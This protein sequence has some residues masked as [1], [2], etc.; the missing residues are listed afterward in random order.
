MIGAADE[1]KG[2]LPVGLLA[3]KAGV[4]RPNGDIAG[5][6]VKMVR[7]QIGAVASFKTATVVGR[8]PK[9][10]SGKIL[11][12][13]MREIADSEHYKTPATITLSWQRRI[14]SALAPHD[15]THVQFVLLASLWWL[16]DHE[17]EAPSQ[18]RLA[19]QAGTDPMMTSQV[20]RKLEARGLLERA[21]DP[22]DTRAR[23]LHLPPA[24]RDLIAGAL[25]DVER[26]DADYFAPLAD[27]HGAFIEALAA[28][29]APPTAREQARRGRR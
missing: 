17:P 22:A 24:G 12:A 26:V 28:L 4:Q 6:V 3:L 9:T 27:R 19:E 10:R 14:R 16:G 29:A 7:D 5:E 25:A 15:L 13:T 23:R 2:Q 21:R 1:L 8:L 11:R 20:L 18:A